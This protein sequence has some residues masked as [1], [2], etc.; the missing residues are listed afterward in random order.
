MYITVHILQAQ[1]EQTCACNKL[2]RK[3]NDSLSIV[4]K[5]L[6]PKLKETDTVF[7]MHRKT[8]INQL[9]NDIELN[10]QNMVMFISDSFVMLGKE[11]GL[12][13]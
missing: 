12:Q 7:S 13:H 10:L 3:A 1:I 2:E 5:E 9:N 4:R 11:I 8:A 6:L